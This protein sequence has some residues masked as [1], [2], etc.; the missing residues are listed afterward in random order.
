MTIFGPDGL[1]I[2][3]LS[4]ILASIRSR[5]KAAYGDDCRVDDVDGV[6]GRH[7]GVLSETKNHCLSELA[8]TVAGLLPSTS[9][10]A[11]LE[12]MVKFNGI[13]KNYASKSTVILSVTANE[14]GSTIPDLALVATQTG[15]EF[16]I[17]GPVV[18]APYETKTNVSA[19][20]VNAGAYAAPAGTITQILTPVYGWESVT[21]A[22]DAIVGNAEET[23]PALR[24]RRWEAAQAVGLHHPSMI[25]KALRN[26]PDVTEVAVEINNG[27]TINENGVPPGHVRA[28]VIGGDDQDIAD[29]LFG[30]TGNPG[31]TAIGIAG[32]G[33]V[34]AGIGTYGDEEVVS[35]DTVEGQ[36]ETMYFDRGEWVPIY[37]D[38]R[39]KIDYAEF[40]MNGPDLIIAAIL[41]FFAGTLEIND[42]P[43]D[44]FKL[45][46][47][48]VS[49]RLYTPC[50]AVP[51][52][53]VRSVLI[54]V[55]PNPTSDS[56]IPLSIN[57]IAT[58]DATK[59]KVT[60]V[61]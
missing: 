3:T 46:D 52:H 4:E 44:K 5:Y 42:V 61:P 18:L 31:A 56:D 21:N 49:S 28:I 16:E 24:K 20:A 50:N 9:T 37:I 53:S 17:S 34:A 57:Q 51:G 38:V 10:G 29:T 58:T 45:G 32:A 25:K 15:I 12:E 35:T 48:V 55:A 47:D 54:S 40:P 30:K 8:A 14:A 22:A 19:T 1:D 11:L 59:I 27:T 2:P 13:T 60:P 41:E 23:D 7:A 33:S 43:V 39:T 36:S 26:L 6:V